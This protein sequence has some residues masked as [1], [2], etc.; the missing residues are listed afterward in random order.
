MKIKILSIVDHGQP[1]SVHLN[2]NGA[3]RELPMNTEVEVTDE[4]FLALGHSDHTI[5]ILVEGSTAADEAEQAPAPAGSGDGGDAGGGGDSG[6]PAADTSETT[7]EQPIE[8][9]PPIDPATLPPPPVNADDLSLQ[10]PA[11]TTTETAAAT[12]NLAQIEALLPENFL[13]RS[14]DVI[15]VELPGLTAAQLVAAKALEEGGKTRKG[16]MSALDAA[17]AAAAQA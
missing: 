3:A 8:Q 15:V 12:Q 9:D 5:E 1:A 14:I 2:I 4:E 11:D 16:L 13:D 10:A 7:D 17:I 6:E